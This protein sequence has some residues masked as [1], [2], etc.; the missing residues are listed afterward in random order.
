MTPRCL[1]SATRQGGLAF[2]EMEVLQGGMLWG[3]MVG[4]CVWNR[5]KLRCVG[6]T[7]CIWTYEPGV[8]GSGLP[9]RPAAQMVCDSLIIGRGV[10]QAQT[11]ASREP[12]T[13][14][15]CVFWPPQA[16]VTPGAYT[17]GV[18]APSPLATSHY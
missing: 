7:K 6:N 11:W 3:G 2:P 8:Q 5:L 10:D 16:R 12:G 9:W 17:E 18:T 14:P 15:G 1:I 4:S 13:G